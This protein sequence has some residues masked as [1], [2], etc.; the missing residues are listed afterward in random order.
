[1]D[2][3]QT[4]Q[5]RDNEYAFILG[6]KF[7]RLRVPLHG[8]LDLTQRCNLRCAHCYLGDKTGIPK[9]TTRE[10]DTAQWLSIIDEFTEAGCLFLLLTGG[11]PLLRK[12]FAEIYSHTKTSGLVVTVF[13]NGT[14]ITDRVLSLFEDLPPH[15]VEVSLYGATAATYEKISGIQG[16]YRQCMAGIEKLFE[17]D[18][19]FGLKTVLMTHNR[20]EL[21]AMKK[22]A[23]K[24]GV[25]F[26]F[27]AAIFP[28]FNGDRT[29]LA[30][31]VSPKEAIDMELSDGD[32]VR[33]WKDYLE[34]IKSYHISDTLY[35]CGAGMNSFHIDPHGNLQP[36]LMV[37]GLKYN[38]L[39]G[40][41]LTG[42]RDAVPRIQER[43]A[44]NDFECFK[45][46]KIVLC[47]F[48]PAFFNLENGSPEILSDY[49]CAMGQ[50]RFQAIIKTD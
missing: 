11:E 7:N 40:S 5:Q 30:L 4:R 17:H 46:D 37:T 23:K 20:H 1:M 41:F 24:Y 3:T 48:C 38:L 47:D 49:L 29:P 10:L 16:S 15:G 45:C 34:K 6:T 14:L 13:T 19:K 26:R 18:I 50:H 39:N 32:M 43:K 9:N 31:R 35:G 21:F 8:S 12:D 2:A 44:S 36:C 28:C 33:Q 25:D 42:W 27:D 22:M